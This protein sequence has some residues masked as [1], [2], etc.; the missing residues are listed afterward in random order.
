[1]GES[2]VKSFLNYILTLDRSLPSFGLIGK[3]SLK[4]T[5]PPQRRSFA[6]ARSSRLEMD[7]QAGSNSA[8]SELATALRKL[9]NRSREQLRN[10]DYARGAVATIVNNVVGNGIKF[11]AQVGSGKGYSDRRNELIENLF[12]KWGKKQNCDMANRLS[13]CQFQRLALRS[14]IESGEVFIRKH[15]SGGLIPFRLELIESD[16][17]EDEYGYSPSVSNTGN[18]VK[19]GIEFDPYGKVMAYY[20]RPFH[21]GDLLFHPRTIASGTNAPYGL[22]RVPAD[23]IIHLFIP[24][25]PGQSRGIPWLSSSLQR[26]KNLGGYEEAELVAARARAAVMG[27]RITKDPDLS[28]LDDRGQPVDTLEPG[29]IKEL[30]PGEE[31]VGFDPTR[32]NDAFEPFIRMMLR[33]VAA[34][35]GIDFESVSRD[36][37][38]SN[39]SSSRLALIQVRDSYRSLQELFIE[40]FLQP[41]FEA[42]LDITI[43]NGS[44]SFP[45]Y[46]SNPD[47]YTKVRW[48]PRGWSWV[49]PW[50]ETQASIEAINAGLST[51]TQELSKQGLDIQEVLTERASEL[52]LANSLGLNLLTSPVQETPDTANLSDSPDFSKWIAGLTEQFEEED[53]LDD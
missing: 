23:Q 7:W 46:E 26:L 17:I 42:W 41:I 8:D 40:T 3:R 44:L 14:M 19:M 36:F 13:F 48:R 53:D 11:Q 9:R 6:G 43:L 33:G 12:E 30:A 16:R 49:D 2:T 52:E 20:L 29:T 15:Y 1:M 24:E 25:R 32:P 21:P 31:F 10:N 18:L 35:L 50:K 34:N 27:F 37:S 38:Q 45:D 5:T 51:L 47:R 4:A 39:Y 28:E 22:E